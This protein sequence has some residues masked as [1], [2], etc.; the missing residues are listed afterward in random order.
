MFYI[1]LGEFPVELL[2][3]Q[4]SM[5]FA[6]NLLEYMTSPV[7]SFAYFTDF[8]NLKGHCHAIWQLYKKLKGVFTSIEFQN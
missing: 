2:A 4:V 5:V 6:A 1:A 3:Y 8:S 7:I